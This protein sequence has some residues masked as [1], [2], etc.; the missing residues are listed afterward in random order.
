MDIVPGSIRS[1]LS[2]EVRSENKVD[3]AEDHR[4]IDAKKADSCFH[5]AGINM[6]TSHIW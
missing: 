4:V 2:S 3:F 6:C 5:F 1:C